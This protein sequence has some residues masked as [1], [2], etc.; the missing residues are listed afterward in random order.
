V[1]ATGAA[2]YVGGHFRW[3][4]NPY[5]GDAAGRGATARTGLAAVDPRNGLPFSWN[6]TRARGVGVWEFM[7]TQAGLWVGHDTNITGGETRKRIALF[8]SAGG[9]SLPAENTGALPGNVYLLGHTTD[10]VVTRR[11]FTGASVTTSATVGNGGQDW[12]SSRGA[13]MI[14]GTLYTGWSDGTLKARTYDGTTFG[15]ATNVN[16]NGLTDFATELPMISGLTYDRV[17]GRLYYTLSGQSSLYYRYFEPESRLVGAVRF[18]ATGNA[19]GIDWSRANGL[20]LNGSTL[21]VGSSATGNL[22]AVGWAGGTLTGTAATV[23]GP[24][25]DGFDWRTRGSFIYAG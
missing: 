7:T 20:F 24:A 25:V 12:S 3:L 13:V 9:T 8:P 14:D 16:L 21:Y 23:S 10:D 22:A 15:A 5:A 11:A 4:N 2:I 19:N 1:K 18:T 17:Q 6:P